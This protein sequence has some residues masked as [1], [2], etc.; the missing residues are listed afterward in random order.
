MSLIVVGSSSGGSSRRTTKSA[1]FTGSID[2]RE[3]SRK[4]CQAA[5][6]VI[7]HNAMCG[8]IRWSGPRTPPLRVSRLTA[9]QTAWS[10]CIGTTGE[11]KWILK[12]M[13]RSSAER[14]GLIHGVLTLVLVA[15]RVDKVALTK[16]KHGAERKKLVEVSLRK[17]GGLLGLVLRVDDGGRLA[18]KHPHVVGTHRIRASRC[19]RVLIGAS[20]RAL[21]RY[22][23]TRHAE[24]GRR[25]GPVTSPA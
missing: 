22:A 14:R 11:S 18:A 13:P 20:H 21:L 24:S 8:E 5:S 4:F 7:A 12:R 23:M 2:P 17:P 10:G 25:V 6:A 19:S 15:L 9:R 1:S 16:A 3:S